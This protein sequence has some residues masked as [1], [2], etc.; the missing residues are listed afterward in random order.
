MAINEAFKSKLKMYH[1]DKHQNSSKEEK[2]FYVKKTTE[3]IEAYNT[4][5]NY[6]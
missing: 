1:P 6:F 3:L 2:E 5:K 4:V